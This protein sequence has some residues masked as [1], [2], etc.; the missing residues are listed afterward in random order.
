MIPE[1]A[2]WSF[3]KV[4]KKSTRARPSGR[5]CSPSFPPLVFECEQCVQK[6]VSVFKC[7]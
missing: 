6:W 7:V 2:P 3:K 4:N 1:V 5:K